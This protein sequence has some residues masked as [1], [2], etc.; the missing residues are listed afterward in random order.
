[1]RATIE[2][3]R[4]IGLTRIELSV[5]EDNRSAAALYRKFGFEVEGKQRKAILLDGAYENL[6]GMALLFD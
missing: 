3:A 2:R 6:I 5:R 4:M 1:M